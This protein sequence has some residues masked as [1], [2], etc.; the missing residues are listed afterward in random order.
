M[1][2]EYLYKVVAFDDKEVLGFKVAVNSSVGTI[3]DVH[4]FID[5][6]IEKYPT[7]KWLLLPIMWKQE[8]M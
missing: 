7:C 5:E 2:N 8:S 1:A 4:K 3:N 6:N